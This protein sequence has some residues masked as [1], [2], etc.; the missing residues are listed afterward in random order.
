MSLP[1]FAQLRTK[2][3]DLAVGL[4]SLETTVCAMVGENPFGVIDDVVLRNHIRQLSIRQIQIALLELVAANLLTRSY[5]WNC[6]T[7]DSPIMEAHKVADFPDSM[8]CP[9]GHENLFSESAVEVLFIP[10]DHLRAVATR[11]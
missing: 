5:V 9:C 3:P 6:Q 4:D 11:R 8:E 10:S 7:C 1:A 2:H